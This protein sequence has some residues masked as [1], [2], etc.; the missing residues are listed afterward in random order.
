MI[1]GNMR[2]IMENRNT[3]E[4]NAMMNG[5]Q[6]ENG[7][8]FSLQH[9][10][11][12]QPYVEVDV[13]PE[14]FDGLTESEARQM[15]VLVMREWFV[16]VPQ[17]T[18]IGEAEL[19][20]RGARHIAH[21]LEGGT[22]EQKMMKLRATREIDNIM[23]AARYTG[24]EEAKHYHPEWKSGSDAV[25]GYDVRIKLGPVEGEYHL[26]VGNR[27]SGTPEIYD[28]RLKENTSTLKGGS[29]V[30]YSF[31]SVSR[32]DVYTDNL[33]NNASGVKQKITNEDMVFSLKEPVEQK[34]DLVAVHNLTAEKLEGALELGGM[35]M[36]SIAVTKTDIG[37]STYGEVSLVFGKD[38]VD[39]K[40]KNNKVC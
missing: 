9:D 25:S 36:P 40:N 26:T 5:R 17:E 10:K 19:S 29:A 23:K 32:A 14:L 7:E 16:N 13:D 6:E 1:G 21:T 34:R 15:A 31:R 12:N 20:N 2:N 22:A 27:H 30:S 4:W 11:N 38:T 18:E 33:P 37:H 35:P 24:P 39:P 3:D 28:L 8:Q